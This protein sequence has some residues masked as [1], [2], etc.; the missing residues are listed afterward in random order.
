MSS[1]PFHIHHVQFN[2]EYPTMDRH[3]SPC[4]F[5]ARLVFAGTFVLT[6]GLIAIVWMPA[7]AFAQPLVGQVESIECLVVN[8]ELVLVGRIVKID[9]PSST[10]EETENPNWQKINTVFEVAQTLKL[11]AYN[12]V[13][14]TRVQIRFQYPR[15]QLQ[16][17][18]AESARL[19][20]TVDVYGSAASKVI[21][22]AE[23][24]SQVMSSEMRLVRD[25]NEVVRIAEDY[26]AHAPRNVK[27]LHTFRRRVPRELVSETSWDE[28]YRTS[29]LLLLEVP[30]DS[31]LEEWAL[32]TLESD[33]YLDRCDAAKALRF[34]RSDENTK[35]LRKLL[36]DEG[37]SIYRHPAE[38]DGIEV[39][40]YGVR[41]EAYH[42]L[43]SWGL[44]V[45]EP[46]HLKEVRVPETRD[47]D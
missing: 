23:G 21:E 22:L 37:W 29:G 19:L 44:E 6:C 31:R 30:A 43:K 17:W 27:Q 12:D 32:N 41:M 14:Y 45:E 35:R 2:L 3:L 9:P 42:S 39:R 26:L 15:A 38:N 1:G 36:D 8:S 20:I 18:M 33:D 16:E 28:Y 34:F 5:G 11:E 40:Y 25:P 13:P 10:D 47:S 24:R 4:N 46:D 7:H